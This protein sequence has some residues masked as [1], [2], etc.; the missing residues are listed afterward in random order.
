MKK[1]IFAFIGFCSVQFSA[2]DTSDIFR[3]SHTSITGT[4]RFNA[5][6]GAFGALG[7]D[8]SAVSIN[9]ASSSIFS[10]N[11]VAISAQSS[12]S[13]TNSN[14]FGTQANQRYNSF[15][16]NQAGGVFI[17]E[18]AKPTAKWKKF[19]VA[20][21]YENLNNFD[22]SIFTKGVN[23]TQTAT[24]FFVNNANGIPLNNLQDILYEN[25]NY[26]GQ[27]AS[28]AYQSFLINPI[29]TAPINTL[30]LAN[31]NATGNFYQENTTTT[32]GY[33]GKVSFNASA[34]YKDNLYIG[35][36]LNAHFSDFKKSTKFNENFTNSSNNNPTIGIQSYS[37]NNDLYTYGNGFSFQLGAIYKVTTQL[38]AG[39]SYESPTW[40]RLNDE[41]TQSLQTTC[42]DCPQ[43]NYTENPSITNIY[44]PYNLQTPSKITASLAY[45]FGKK[46]LISFD[47]STKNYGKMQYNTD[48]LQTVNST[49]QSTFT[50]ANQYK[51]GIEQRYKQWSFRGGYRLEQSPYKNK[52]LMSD[53]KGYSGGFGYNFGSTKLD[54]TYSYSKHNGFEQFFNQGMT[55]S[56]NQK[57]INNN[58]LVSL[59]FEL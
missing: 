12:N 10:N 52:N 3:Y 27:Q 43:T 8:M 31:T 4:A 17:F 42:A 56:A 44:Q 36:N 29:N 14:Y 5:M 18:D 38:R 19:A 11:F 35:L 20:I 49:I 45:V 53:L 40:M 1:I 59:G 46:G 6:A 24:Q 50:R 39:F 22:N 54:L 9:P 2:Q 21:N 51:I 48:D 23:P 13:A 25:F 33:N 58:V 28:L 16:I 47:Y 55:S 37:F 15:D 32:A 34:Q 26:Q 57:T 7:G 30:Y 41:L